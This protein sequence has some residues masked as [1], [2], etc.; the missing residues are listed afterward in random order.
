LD[1]AYLSK[2][3]DDQ[4][5]WFAQMEVFD[6]IYH[7]FFFPAN[8]LGRQPTTSQYFHPLAPQT[9]ALVAAAIHCTLSE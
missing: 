9:L 7:Q 8:S 3:V 2:I 5:S 6:L 4:I 1:D